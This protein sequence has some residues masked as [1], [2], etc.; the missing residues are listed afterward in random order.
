MKKLK[1]SIFESPVTQKTS[2]INNYRTTSAKS[3]SLNIINDQ[4]E[5][6]IKEYLKSL[7]I[8]RTTNAYMSW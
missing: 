3:M 4:G 7:L 1:N 6:H 8:G 5:K 2:N